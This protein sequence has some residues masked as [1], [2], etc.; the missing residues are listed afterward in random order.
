[1]SGSGNPRYGTHWSDETRAKICERLTG[2]KQSAELCQRKSEWMKQAWA[3]GKFDNRPY[4]GGKKR[5]PVE[6]VELGQQF[7]SI[8]EA[9][10]FCHKNPKNK[11]NLI[12]C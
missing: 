9:V 3:D 5:R 11:Q 6:C 12:K 4:L 10:Q 2:Q 1:M 8:S 7:D